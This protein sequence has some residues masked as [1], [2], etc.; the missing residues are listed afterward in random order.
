MKKKMYEDKGDRQ[1]WEGGTLFHLEPERKWRSTWMMD[2]GRCR[3]LHTN[4]T[5]SGVCGT[6]RLGGTQM[7]ANLQNRV[8][9]GR[10]WNS[11]NFES[12]PCVFPNPQT[13]RNHTL[14]IFLLFPLPWASSGLHF[15]WLLHKLDLI[16]FPHATPSLGVIAAT[17]G[18]QPQSYS[19]ALTSFLNSRSQYAIPV[20]LFWGVLVSE[21]G[22]VFPTFQVVIDAILIWD[23]QGAYLTQQNLRS[24]EWKVRHRSR[25]W[26]IFSTIISGY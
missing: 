16:F 14:V 2:T 5:L 19:P 12:S 3:H 9:R 8:G 7:R 17:C 10:G 4:D 21:R 24:K 20:S 13:S 25:I 22:G 15:P 23:F 1:G 11:V 26:G 6:G 18:L